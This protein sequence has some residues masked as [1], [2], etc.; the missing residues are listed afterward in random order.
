MVSFLL[1]YL[2]LSLIYSYA[3][4]WSLSYSF[5]PCL[6]LLSTSIPYTGLISLS[7]FMLVSLPTV[8]SDTGLFLTPLHLVLVFL[9][10][11]IPYT[12][13][14]HTPLLSSG[15]FTYSYTLHWS[16]S[17]PS[18]LSWS[19]YLLLHL[20]LVHFTL[21]YLVLVFLPSS[22]PYTDLF[23]PPLPC[24]GLST[25]SYTLHW[26]LSHSST[27]CWSFYLI[28]Y[29]VLVSFVLLYHY[30]GLLPTP[31]QYTGIFLS[32]LPYAGLFTYFY[33]FMVVQTWQVHLSLTFPG[34]PDKIFK[35]SLTFLCGNF[36]F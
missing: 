11:L 12:G 6:A 15:H 35:N 13:L 3:L 19:L 34:V 31:I 9:P 1:I 4:K 24:T 26:S 36:G 5:T 18:T 29:L 30:I 2:V 28:L 16:L 14:F 25:H 22:I 33:T 7:Y 27:W 17:H 32:P 10:T 20:T 21:L 23:H 8:L